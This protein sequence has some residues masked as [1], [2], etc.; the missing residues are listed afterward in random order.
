MPHSRMRPGQPRKRFL[1]DGELGHS[2]ERIAAVHAR[3]GDGVSEVRVF[4]SGSNR[5]REFATS[6]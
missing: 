3:A 4:F 5:H 2:T 6:Q 1:G